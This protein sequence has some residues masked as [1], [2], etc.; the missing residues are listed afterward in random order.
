M[1]GTAP[2]NML[3]IPGQFALTSDNGLSDPS[4]W[5]AFPADLQ[6]LTIAEI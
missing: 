2:G 5:R 4:K 3:H 1:M 6:S